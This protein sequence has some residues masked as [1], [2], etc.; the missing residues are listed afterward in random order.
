[1]LD[2]ELLAAD[3]NDLPVS[4]ISEESSQQ[5]PSNKS[6]CTGEEGGALRW[7]VRNELTQPPGCGRIKASPSDP[8]ELSLDA[9]A[10]GAR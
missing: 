9:D 3:G 6:R 10:N 8:R 1:M 7:R 2:A 4:R 5:M